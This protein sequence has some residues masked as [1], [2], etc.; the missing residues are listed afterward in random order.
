MDYPG[1]LIS[2]T[3]VRRYKRFFA[4]V[5]LESGG[6]I[7]AHCPNPGSMLGLATPGAK[8]WLSRSDSPTR[9]L[10]HTLVEADGSFVGVNTMLPNRLVEEAL[11]AGAIPELAGYPTLRR[12]VRYGAASRVDFLLEHPA[13]PACYLEVKSVTL[14]RTPGLA[15]FP[16]S[17][18]A[19]AAGH[20]E[21]LEGVVRA[22][23]RA[24][25]FFL[26]QRTDCAAF[27]V[28][29]DIDPTFAAALARATR[30]GVDVL[31]YGC[32]ITPGGVTLAAPIEWKIR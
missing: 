30:G 13:R 10:A 21:E 25:A 12:E 7:T 18:S 19:R 26:V 29:A 8:V 27:T 15:E 20:L 3:L 1:P 24:V 31:C 16:D 28:A 11:R 5:A 6:E 23:F 2:A 17:V 22:G 9:K 14:A 32:E 4:D